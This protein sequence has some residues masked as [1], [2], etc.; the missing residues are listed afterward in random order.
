MSD[1]FTTPW[2]VVSRFLC[3]WNFPGKNTGVGCHF[4]LQGSSWPRD[5]TWVSCIGRLVLYH[6]APREAQRSSK[7]KQTQILI[8]AIH[9]QLSLNTNKKLKKKKRICL[10]N[11]FPGAADTRSGDHALPGSKVGPKLLLWLGG[12]YLKAHH[13]V[14]STF[15]YIWVFNNKSFNIKSKLKWSRRIHRGIKASDNP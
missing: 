5:Q 3:P 14:L 12:G 8:Q 2:A 13:S 4:L 11:K 15:E 10:S 1:S 9:Y 7:V 6:G